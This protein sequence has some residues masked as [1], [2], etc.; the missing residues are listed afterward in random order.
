MRETKVVKTEPHLEDYHIQNHSL[1]K[2]E[3]VNNQEIYNK[4]T[5][6]DSVVD[7]TIYTN[8]VVDNWV[9]LT[10]SRDVESDVKNILDEKFYE[11]EKLHDEFMDIYSHLDKIKMKETGWFGYSLIVLGIIAVATQIS[12]MGIASL[13]YVPVILLGIV[14]TMINSSIVKK[15]NSKKQE[16]KSNLEARHVII[17]QEFAKIGDVCRSL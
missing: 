4:D 11:N 12:S 7:G 3:L 10:F 13:I 5:T 14:I 16:K 15:G 6:I 9:K 8:T 1:F 2:W 17:K